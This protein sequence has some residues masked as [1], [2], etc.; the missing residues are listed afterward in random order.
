MMMIENARRRFL[1]GAGLAV[2][3]AILGSTIPASAAQI[4][5][6]MGHAIRYDVRAFGAVG[7]GTTVD[8]SAINRAIDAAAAAGGGT[9]YFPAGN[10]VCYSIHLMSKVAI[11][12]DA[13]A[14]IVAADPASD[15][16]KSYDLAESDRKS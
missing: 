6:E 11:Y 2:P 14:T 7:D 12:L 1:K 16:A 10:Y 8:T 5:A 3:G 4:A 15:T 13:G 9:V